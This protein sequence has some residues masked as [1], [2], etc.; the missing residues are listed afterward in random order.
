MICLYLILFLVFVKKCGSEFFCF[1]VLRMVFKYLLMYIFGGFIIK[2]LDFGIDSEEGF[3]CW[4]VCN[5]LGGLECRWVGWLF[6]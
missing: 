5:V 6:V 3:E 4:I 1:L 2:D